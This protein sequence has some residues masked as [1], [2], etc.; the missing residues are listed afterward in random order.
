M[1]ADGVA[2][3]GGGGWFGFE[4]VCSALVERTS[5]LRKGSGR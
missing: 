3:R 2:S 4:E 5:I 1:D